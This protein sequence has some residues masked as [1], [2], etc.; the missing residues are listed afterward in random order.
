MVGEVR[1]EI[2]RHRAAGAPLAP[3]RAAAVLA[4][5]LTAAG[6]SLFRSAPPPLPPGAAGVTLTSALVRERYEPVD[7]GVPGRRALVRRCEESRREGCRLR[8][9]PRDRRTS[10]AKGADR[11]VLALVSLADRP[12]GAAHAVA[13]RFR[14][15]SGEEVATVRLRVNV[16]LDTPPGSVVSFPCALALDPGAPTGPWRMEL[17]VDGRREVTLPF[18]VTEAAR[19]SGGVAA[20]APTA[21]PRPA[22]KP[23]S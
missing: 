4:V 7:L 6:C 8:W 15:P 2:G 11:Q 21:P 23:R 22:P 19:G 16:P 1:G 20:P 3:G 5:A 12:P 14:D 9:S 18:A 10:F 13:C 17:L